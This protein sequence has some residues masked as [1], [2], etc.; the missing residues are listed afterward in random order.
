MVGLS[1]SIKLVNKL[2]DAVMWGARRLQEER[3][4][5]RWILLKCMH[6]F[7]LGRVVHFQGR[8]YR[9]FGKF[10]L[11][12]NPAGLISSFRMKFGV[13][14]DSFRIT[15]VDQCGIPLIRSL[16][17]VFDRRIVTFRSC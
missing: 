7:L 5:Y 6:V 4:I 9:F 16:S 17:D 13:G 8:L 15:S 2:G 11:E 12:V 10:S 1:F 14:L 3:V